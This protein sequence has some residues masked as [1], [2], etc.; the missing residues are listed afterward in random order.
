MRFQNERASFLYLFSN[1]PSPG[2]PGEIGSRCRSEGGHGIQDVSQYCTFPGPWLMETWGRRGRRGAEGFEP[3]SPQNS[4]GNRILMASNDN[5][6]PVVLETRERIEHARAREDHGEG[7]RERERDQIEFLANERD[8]ERERKRKER[9]GER[10]ERE[11][12]GERN[13]RGRKSVGTRRKRGTMSPSVPEMLSS[14]R[15]LYHRRDVSDEKVP[16]TNRALT[17]VSR[18]LLRADDPLAPIVSTELQFARCGCLSA[19]PLPPLPLLLLLADPKGSST[20]AP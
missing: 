19:L 8:E 6:A 9:E 10:S 13:E 11:E 1:F 20:P 15:R 2:T 18:I 5:L 12:D 7:E 17:I 14:W 3:L 16:G 4:A